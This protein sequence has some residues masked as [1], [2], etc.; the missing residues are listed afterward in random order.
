MS[1]LY[2]GDLTTERAVIHY[3]D[4][5]TLY[6]KAGADRVTVIFSTVFKGEDDVILGR[7]FLQEFNEGRKIDRRRISVLS[8]LDLLHYDIT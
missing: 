4:D 8:G 5:E 2:S 1:S 3:R 6:V 7:V